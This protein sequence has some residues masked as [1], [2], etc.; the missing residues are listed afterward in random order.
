MKKIF[1]IGH[2]DLRIFLK[3]RTGYFWLFVAPALFVFFFGFANRPPGDPSNPRPG[4]L[5]E[6]RDTGGLGEVLITEMGQQGLAILE[7]A[8][9][10]QARRGIRIP[11]DFSARLRAGER[12]DVEFFKIEDSQ[13]AVEFMVELR[14]I[15][16]L[17][18]MNTHLFRFVVE[19]G[20]LDSIDP[21]ELAG[22]LAGEDPV[23]LTVE[24][25]SRKPLPHGFNQTLP[26]TLVMFLLMN[27]T[28]FGASSISQLRL[29]GVIKRMAV[30]P[31]GKW[32]LVTGKIYGLFLLAVIQ[33]AVFLLLGE[34]VFS[35]HISH[36]PVGISLVLFL[37]SWMA[38]SFGV[39]IG[40]YVTSPE[41][42]YGICIGGSLVM[43][44]FGGCWWPM[45]IL[46]D[47]LNRFGHLFPT[48]WAMDALNQLIS[49]GADIR[50]IVM[51]LVILFLFAAASHALANISLR[52]K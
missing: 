19:G 12:V 25:G 8:E 6:N 45:E 16:A 30:Y 22:R 3:D 43:A 17:L 26:G 32:Q 5:I 27:L 20:E 51:E 36:N 37:F 13:E 39:L 29:S 4:V 35:V 23:S 41:K 49:F 28:I 1:L 34:F 31:M 46:S 40:A 11:E 42:T 9:R 14:L 50:H 33:I 38:A 18:S 44:A 7:P 15:R 21:E 48:A 10:D 47:G 24:W 52:Y 2:L